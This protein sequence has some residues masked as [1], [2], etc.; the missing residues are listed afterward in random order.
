M[1]EGAISKFVPYWRKTAA[2]G[3]TRERHLSRAE[4]R[5]TG[6]AIVG[7]YSR[8]RDLKKKRLKLRHKFNLI[9]IDLGHQ[10][11]DRKTVRRFLLTILEVI[12]LF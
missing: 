5:K 9:K 12:F 11:L 8:N 7:K 10:N 1:I 3:A 4:L 2:R 6:S